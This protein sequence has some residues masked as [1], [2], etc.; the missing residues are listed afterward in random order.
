[1][2]FLLRIVGYLTSSCVIDDF[3]VREGDSP[4]TYGAWLRQQWVSALPESGN[5]NFVGFFQVE[6]RQTRYGVYLCM[7]EGLVTHSKSFGVF[8]L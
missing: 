8:C 7:Y 4:L 6:I 2:Y 3:D 1:M 5:D